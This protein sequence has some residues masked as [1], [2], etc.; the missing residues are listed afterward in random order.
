MKKYILTLIFLIC[1]PGCVFS[2]AF[3]IENN[4]AIDQRG[5]NKAELV[6][7]FRVEGGM[8]RFLVFI[9]EGITTEIGPVRSLREVMVDLAEGHKA[10]LVFYGQSPKAGEMIK[11][12]PFDHV[13]NISKVIGI[14]AEGNKIKKKNFWR[15]EGYVYEHSLYTSTKLIPVKNHLRYQTSENFACE[16]CSQVNFSFSSV[17]HVKWIYQNRRYIRKINLKEY[18]AD[19]L[20]IIRAAI[21]TYDS[22]GRVVYDLYGKN[23]VMIFRDGLRLECEWRRKKGELFRFFHEGE[24]IFL[25]KGTSWI[26]LPG[27]MKY[28]KMELEG[29]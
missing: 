8:T 7:E 12:Y 22:E 15:V 2:N 9:S 6:Y 4:V 17:S 24:E 16:K 13:N 3:V 1:F 29:E 11:N 23:K 25:K 20:V 21:S 26:H 27:I 19:N 10:E 5:L 14:D 18:Q 28:D